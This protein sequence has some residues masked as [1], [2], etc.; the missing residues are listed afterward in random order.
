[1]L[2]FEQYAVGARSAP[3]PPRTANR[4]GRQE[5]QDFE[6]RWIKA[7]TDGA[8]RIGFETSHKKILALLAS[9]ASLAVEVLGGERPS[10]PWHILDAL[11][12][13]SLRYRP[14]LP[15]RFS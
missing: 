2:T 5:R 7:P 10:R 14:C 4:Q 9:L 12:G 8:R 15:T 11:S 1:K 13:F 6:G 3:E